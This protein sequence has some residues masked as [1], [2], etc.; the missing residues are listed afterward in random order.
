MCKM[1]VRKLKDSYLD[2][3][4]M[5]F[6]KDIKYVIKCWKINNENK[7]VTSSVMLAGWLYWCF[8][9]FQHI[10]GHFGHNQLTL[11]H[12][13]WASLLG[14]LPVLSAHSFASNWQLPLL[15]QRK[16]EDGPINVNERMFCRT[17]GSN[18]RPSH[19]RQTHIRSSYRAQPSV[20]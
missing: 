13:S 4:M 1:A 8:M 2:G 7:N 3:K 17:W 20:T 16:G 12:C 18:P 14:S 5:F 10:L 15:T 9:A 6:K 19:I 11:P